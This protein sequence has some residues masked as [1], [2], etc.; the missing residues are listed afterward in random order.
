MMAKI[1]LVKLHT[2]NN[3]LY[4]YLDTQRGWG[5]LLLIKQVSEQSTTPSSFLWVLIFSSPLRAD[6][7]DDQLVLHIRSL[8]S[9]ILQIAA[10]PQMTL[11]RSL[12]KL[13]RVGL[14]VK[15]SWV[16]LPLFIS[17]LQ[18]ILT[19]FD[20]CKLWSGRRQLIILIYEQ[21]FPL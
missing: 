8:G 6:D 21:V 7:C 17:A 4:F 11:R 19:I 10:Y 13:F 12:N 1:H 5:F 18:F 9:H 14:I 15:L 3:Y 16:H 20:F 2:H